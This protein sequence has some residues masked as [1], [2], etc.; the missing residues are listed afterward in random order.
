VNLFLVAEADGAVVGG[1]L[2]H[3]FAGPRTGFSSFLGVRRDMQGKGIARMLHDARFEALEHALDGRVEGVFIDVVSPARQSASERRREAR[4]GSDACARRRAFQR[5]GFRQVDIRYEQP[6]GGPGGGPVTT[7][8]LLYCP[9]HPSSTVAT[10]LVVETMRAYWS[11]WLGEKRAARHA[12]ELEARAS[13]K[14]ELDLLPSD[15]ECLG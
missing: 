10:P 11:P 12:E 5:L 15:A 4:V 2:F 7:L 8:D 3:A 9:R 14:V 6:V 13:G 1:A